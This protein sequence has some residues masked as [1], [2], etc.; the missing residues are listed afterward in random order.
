RYAVSWSELVVVVDGQGG[1]VAESLRFV[2][3]RLSCRGSE[4]RR[5]NLIVD[6]PAHILGPCLTAVAPPGIPVAGGFR[7][8]AAVD[9]DPALFFEHPCQPF[10]FLGKKAA[11][12]EVAFPVLEVDLAVRDIPV[13]ADDDFPPTAGQ[14][15]QVAEEAFHEL[16]FGG[17]PVVAA[18]A[19]RQVD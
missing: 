18:G 17:L 3:G 16:E 2:D 13:A 1:V 6:A 15:C 14:L 8:E 12:L 5:G 19:G 10:P 9:V 7:V 11:V 4:P